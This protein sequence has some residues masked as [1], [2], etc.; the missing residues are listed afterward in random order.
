MN[1]LD[2]YGWPLHQEPADPWDSASTLADSHRSW[3]DHRAWTA[4][5]YPDRETWQAADDRWQALV[6]EV[7]RGQRAWA[8]PELL[9]ATTALGLDGPL[10]H[11][12]RPLPT[13]GVVP[14]LDLLCDLVEDWMPDGT[15]AGADVVLGP[16]ADEDPD[17][18]LRKLAA[19]VLL[20]GRTHLHGRRTLDAWLR[21]LVKP[22]PPLKRALR[23]LDRTPPMLWRISGATWT[24]ALP[25][26]PAACPEGPVE[27]TPVGLTEDPVSHVVAR[28]LRLE[29]GR[30]VAIAPLGLPAVPPTEVLMRRLVLVLWRHRRTNRRAS[31]EDA[32]RARPEV[33]Y[34]TCATWCWWRAAEPPWPG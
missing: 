22:P 16:W 13:S 32:L 18:E 29:D 2:P 10:R 12:R 1:L 6:W 24:P 27:G 23:A 28:L 21:D 9:A 8:D 3:E 20:H 14:T 5:P 25:L 33:L 7:L 11:D 34:R 31:W 26:A 17:R 19:A 4:A 30:S 15:E